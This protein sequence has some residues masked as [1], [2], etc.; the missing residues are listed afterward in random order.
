VWAVGEPLS[1]D[2]AVS[3]DSATKD[4]IAQATV[5]LKEIRRQVVA[6]SSAVIQGDSKVGRVAECEMSNLVADAMLDRVADQA[7]ETAIANS[8]GLRASI[9]VGDVTMG[10]ILTVLPFQNTLATFQISGQRLIDALEN[11]VSQVEEV[12]GW[13]PQG[14]GLKF[15]W[16]PK[17]APNEGR[18]VEIL[19]AEGLGFFPIDRAAIYMAFTNNYAVMVMMVIRCSARV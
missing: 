15:I 11:G 3:E 1:L 8:G 6:K 16:D 13:F 18:V 19:V 14:A 12:K 17:G 4:R 5:L 7:A 2:G 9:D 10:K